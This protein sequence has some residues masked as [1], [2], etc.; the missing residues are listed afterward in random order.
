MAK[1]PT[2]KAAPTPVPNPQGPW[3]VVMATGPLDDIA[4]ELPVIQDGF[5]SRG[6][7][8]DWAKTNYPAE[9]G[10]LCTVREIKHLVPRVTP[11]FPVP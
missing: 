9:Y 5:A 3:S 11:G 6:E 2:T 7:A 8:E 10:T 1:A 4:T